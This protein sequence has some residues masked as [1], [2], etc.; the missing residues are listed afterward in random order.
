MC[1]F[2]FLLSSQVFFCGYF[3][4]ESGFQR[5]NLSLGTLHGCLLGSFDSL[6][7]F[8]LINTIIPKCLLNFHW[9]RWSIVISNVFGNAKPSLKICW[10]YWNYEKHFHKS[11][12]IHMGTLG[13]NTSVAQSHTPKNEWNWRFVFRNCF[14]PSEISEMRLLFICCLCWQLKFHSEPNNSFMSWIK[15]IE[16]F[17]RSIRQ[18]LL[19]SW[20]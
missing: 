20:Q 6:P 2:L 9:R 18:V 17:S 5:L 12:Y 3:F 13:G 19:L 16:I 10:R 15:Y 1:S 4:M 8:S 7:T 11:A 14:W